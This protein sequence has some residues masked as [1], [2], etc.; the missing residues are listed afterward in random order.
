MPV[1]EFVPHPMWCRTAIVTIRSL[2]VG[3]TVC[4]LD[5]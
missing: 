4:H 5:A 3:G 1:L 2:P